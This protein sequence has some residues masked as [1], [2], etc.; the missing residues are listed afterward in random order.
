LIFR[1]FPRKYAPYPG[2][3]GIGMPRRSLNTTAFI[4]KKKE[5]EMPKMKTKSGAKKRF[6]VTATGKV[7]FK[8]SHARHMMMNK[9]KSMKR[10]TRGSSILCESDGTSVLEHWMPYAGPKKSKR[11]ATRKKLAAAKEAAA[12]APAKAKT[13]KKAG[14]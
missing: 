1:G 7:K 12:A 3:A 14:E 8:A 5:M 6:R 11:S 4:S 13:S 9:P 10:K 2:T